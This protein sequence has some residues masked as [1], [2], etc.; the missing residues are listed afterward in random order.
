MGDTST[1][2]SR[3]HFRDS[4]GSML[5]SKSMSGTRSTDSSDN[6]NGPGHTWKIFTLRSPGETEN[7]GDNAFVTIY[8]WIPQDEFAAFQ[9]DD[10]HCDETLRAVLR[11]LD[12]S[13]VEEMLEVERITS[14]SQDA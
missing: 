14:I 2:I 1:S 8:A 9:T 7:R 10:A 5:R 6:S 3:K 4:A 13:R 12:T 11:S